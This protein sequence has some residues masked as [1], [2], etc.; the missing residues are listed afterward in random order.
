MPLIKG[1]SKK[2]V[3]KNIAELQ[4]SKPGLARKKAIATY[5]RRHN[6]DYTTA[7][8]KMSIAIAMAKAGKSKSK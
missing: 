7:K 6:V 5:A 3:G 1:S 8:T 4:R 2:I